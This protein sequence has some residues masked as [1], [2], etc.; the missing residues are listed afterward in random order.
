MRR[1]WLEGFDEAGARQPIAFVAG[2]GPPPVIDFTAY[3]DRMTFRDEHD[4]APWSTY[5]WEAWGHPEI[6]AEYSPWQLLYADEVARRTSESVPLS[7]LLASP[8]ELA[9]RL[10]PVRG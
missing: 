5:S 3:E 7:D 2:R 1:E 4:F 9:T 8:E 6:T 10:E